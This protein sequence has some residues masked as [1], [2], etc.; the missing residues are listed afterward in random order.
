MINLH[1][2]LFEIYECIYVNLSVSMVTVYMLATIYS[3]QKVTEEKMSMIKFK[4][5]HTVTGGTKAHFKVF[6]HGA[7]VQFIT[8]M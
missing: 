3:I 6:E 5:T 4:Y 8:P 1:L 7:S 2:F